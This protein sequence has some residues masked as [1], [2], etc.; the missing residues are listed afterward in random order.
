MN[1]PNY[2][3][4]LSRLTAR[5]NELERLIAKLEVKIESSVCYNKTIKIAI[6]KTDRKF[7]GDPMVYDMVSTIIVK[8]EE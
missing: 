4:E 6:P 3:Y 1:E 8:E 5:I 7:P 2:A